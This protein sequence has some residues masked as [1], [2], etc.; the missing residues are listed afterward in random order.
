MKKKISRY[1]VDKK[2]SLAEKENTWVLESNK[3]ILWVV[4]QRL[5]DRFKVT[6]KNKAVLK[7]AFLLPK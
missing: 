5:D 3:K 2:L 7:I 6:E 1:L 4:N